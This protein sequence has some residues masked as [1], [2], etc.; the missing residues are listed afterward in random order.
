MSTAAV[1]IPVYKENLNGFEKIS[2]AQVRKILGRYQIIFV[3]PEGKIFSYFDEGDK[4]VHFPQKFFQNVD[5][6]SKMMMTLDFYEKFLDYDFILIYQL[7]AFVF[8][9][10]LEYFCGLG[11]DYIGAVW[12]RNTRF[13][14]TY[15]EKKFRP[16]VGNGGFSLRRVKSFCNLLK[17][18]AEFAAQQNYF[19]E[20]S[21]FSFAGAVFADEFKVAPV[22][23]ANEFSVEMLP[24]RVVKKNGGELP[25]GCHDW[26]NF[27]ADFY[28]ETIP[29]F[30]HDLSKLKYHLKTEDELI[31]TY[32]MIWTMQYRLVRRLLN[33]QDVAQYLPKKFYASM[34]VVQ[35]PVTTAIMNSLQ[36]EIGEHIGEIFLY[37]SNDLQ[38]L[39]NDLSTAETPNLLVMP[40]SKIDDETLEKLEVRGIEYG[41]IISFWQEYVNYCVELF[42]G[43]GK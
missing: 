34:R 35:S 36:R 24:A 22:K 5:T 41:K 32:H 33:G 11:Y 42:H 27:S 43:L 28:I 39:I 15:N 12:I 31:V 19:A 18:H 29:K 1:V 21:F 30:G 4:I 23:V 37:D 7:D 13:V 6:Y 9:D 25:F 40:D 26:D 16:K 38:S 8:A 10:K 20:D 2:L 3:A 17:N 14:I